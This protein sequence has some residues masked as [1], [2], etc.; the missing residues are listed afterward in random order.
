MGSIQG[1]TVGAGRAGAQELVSGH[2]QR[3]MDIVCLTCGCINRD[4]NVDK[5]EEK[6]K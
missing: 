4:H 5:L 1:K 6:G 2:L 3:V